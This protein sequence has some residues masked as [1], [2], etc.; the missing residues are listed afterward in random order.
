MRALLALALFAAVCSPALA[1]AGRVPKPAIVIEKS[2]QCVAD[3]DTMRREHMKLLQHQRDRT[4]RE[5]VRTPQYSLTGCIEC[6]ASRRNNSVVGTKDNFCESC[7][8]YVGVKLDCF[9]CHASKPSHDR[10]ER[11]PPSRADTLRLVHP[12]AAMVRAP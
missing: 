4:V 1:E 7:H 11:R 9:E 12:T 10:G 3:T 2:G 8:T 5:G 6:H